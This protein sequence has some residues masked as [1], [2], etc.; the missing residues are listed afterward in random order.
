MLTWVRI[1]KKTANRTISTS[2][3]YVRTSAN[4]GILTPT[5]RHGLEP[6]PAKNVVWRMSK[7]SR[8]ALVDN[9]VQYL[10]Q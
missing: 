9:V 3:I 4:V 6:T 10:R 8:S 1:F 5:F 7:Y 2:S